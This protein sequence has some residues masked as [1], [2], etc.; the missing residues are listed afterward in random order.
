MQ[1]DGY[2]SPAYVGSAMCP[3]SALG[4]GVYLGGSGLLEDHVR[5]AR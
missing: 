2:Q 1:C 4:G 3:N 5:K